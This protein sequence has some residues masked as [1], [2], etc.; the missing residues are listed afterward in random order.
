MKIAVMYSGLLNEKF[1]LFYENHQKFIYDYY[2]TDFFI[3]TYVDDTKSE[4]QL[5]NMINL[6][7]P[8]N[9]DIQK[10]SDIQPVLHEFKLKHIGSKY[11]RDCRPMNALSMFYNIKRAFLSIKDNKYDIIIRNRFDITYSSKLILVINNNLNVPAGGDYRGGLMDLFAY[12]SYTIMAKYCALFDHID[13]YMKNN[14]PFHPETILRYHCI[15]SNIPITRF[16]YDI[17]LRNR[18]FTQSAPCYE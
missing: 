7:H 9:I 4:Q 5:N 11:C 6:L 10:Y 1:N 12:G 15:Q 2:D 3:A 14:I 17:F 16:K 18:N 8:K 13:T